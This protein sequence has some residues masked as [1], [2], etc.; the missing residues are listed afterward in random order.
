MKKNFCNYFH[1]LKAP[2]DD[3]DLRRAFARV[4]CKS[5]FCSDQT[6][7]HAW[8][9]ISEADPSLLV[10]YLS[11]MVC[12]PAMVAEHCVF[13][14][15]HGKQTSRP[16]LRQIRAILPLPPILQIVDWVV[17]DELH[18]WLDRHMPE[19]PACFEGGR[20]GTQVSDV[21]AGVSLALEKG[22]IITE[23]APRRKQTWQFSMIA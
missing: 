18:A 9:V 2:W 7:V 8:K 16:T 22:P 21:A 23:T 3:L 6:C 12:D 20:P 4:K 14:K 1:G 13:A 19:L 17:T 11:K 10:T 5:F 15:L